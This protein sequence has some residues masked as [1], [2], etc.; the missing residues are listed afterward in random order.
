MNPRSAY[1]DAIADKW[2]GWDD[3]VVLQRRMS[4]GLA[5]LGL[6]AQEIV[7]DVGC[8]TGNLTQALLA[9]L[10]DAGKVIAVDISPRMI[11]VAR[12]KVRDPRVAWHVAEADRLP[13]E[14][15]SC[16]RIVCFSVWPHFPDQDAVCRELARVLRP[17]G[18][19]HVWHLN[20]RQKINEIHAGA[21]E[22]VRGDL[23]LP[24]TE[25]A[26]KLVSTG[27]QVTTVLDTAEQYL[28]SASKSAS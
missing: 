16:D 10:G 18:C 4:D 12:A 24:A 20:A 27:L 14:A 19:L 15:Q 9:R 6:G 7:L 22:A 1:F 8:G 3:L 13:L 26:A 28:V 2:D 5:E 11:E 25:T 21:G 17:G 23:L